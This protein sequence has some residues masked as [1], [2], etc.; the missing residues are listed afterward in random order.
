MYE[1]IDKEVLENYKVIRK[2][3][4]GAYGHVWKIEEK[5]TG[6]ILALKKIFGAFKNSTD[7]QR[8]FREIF[9]LDQFDHPHIIK[10]IKVLK[11][12]NK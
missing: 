5:N 4:S 10:L 9:L 12:R 3:G 2:V 7:A 8:T 1:E 11:A 6:K